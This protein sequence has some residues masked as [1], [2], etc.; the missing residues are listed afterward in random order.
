MSKQITEPTGEPFSASPELG[1]AFGRIKIGK[2]VDFLNSDELLSN[3]EAADLRMN[4]AVVK[5]YFEYGPDLSLWEYHRKAS[6]EVKIFT[7]DDLISEDI[8]QRYIEIADMLLVDH[9]AYVDEEKAGINEFLARHPRLITKDEE[10]TAQLMAVN[11]VHR[12]V[13]PSEML[14][15][16]SPVQEITFWS[17]ST[18]TEIQHPSTV[19][20]DMTALPEEYSQ[21]LNRYRTLYGVD[22]NA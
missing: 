22:L 14:G 7:G 10:N 3:K 9:L 2:I 13:T 19:Y 6:K 18:Q 11:S 16:I 8:L 1:F 20:V 5:H 15:G 17:D 4:L 21:S 12:D